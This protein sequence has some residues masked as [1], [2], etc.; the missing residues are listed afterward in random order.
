MPLKLLVPSLLRVNSGYAEPHVLH[1]LLKPLLQTARSASRK[2]NTELPQIL[3]NGGGA[4]EIEESMVWYALSYEKADDELWTRNTAVAG[5]WEDVQWRAKWL[6]CME[7]REYEN[8]S[9]SELLTD[10]PFR[11]QIQ[12]LL[13]FLIVSLP[14]PPPPLPTPLRAAKPR[15]G[16][17]NGPREATE[18]REEPVIERPPRECLEIFMDKL[19]MWQLME[20][21]GTVSKSFDASSRDKPLDWMQIFFQEIVQPQSA[22]PSSSRATSPE[23]QASP[24]RSTTSSKVQTDLPRSLSV[25]LAQERSERERSVT[26]G[27]LKKRVLNREV[28]MSRAFKPKARPSQDDENKA[29]AAETTRKLEEAA[30]K[31]PVKAQGVLL[32]EATPTKPKHSRSASTFSFNGTRT[33]SFSLQSSLGAKDD[34]DDDEDEWL[35]PGSSS[36]DVL[37][38]GRGRG[39]DEAQATGLLA[40]TPTKRSRLR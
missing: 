21:I 12:I 15:K 30:K 38:L 37:L 23:R 20:G 33:Q 9:S 14:E 28:S 32:V 24:A 6:E 26:A 25:S 18:P 29:K 27:A 8:S 22:S 16:K 40:D 3:S 7:Q 34:G 31:A 4:G 19:S 35:L 36:P 17:R 1:T 2:Y 11:Y 39:V 10:Q 5:P 13:Y